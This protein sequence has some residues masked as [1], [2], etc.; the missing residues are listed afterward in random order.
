MTP[1]AELPPQQP[2][3]PPT[4]PSSANPSSS[5]PSPD[6]NNP[7]PLPPPET[8]ERITRVPDSQRPTGGPFGPGKPKKGGFQKIPPKF[9]GPPRPAGNF[10]RPQGNFNRPQGNFNRPSGNFDRPQGNFNRP[11]GNFDR[12]QGNFNRPQGNFDRPQGNFNR[13]AGNFDRPQ[14]GNFSRVFHGPPGTPPPAP[15]AGPVPPRPTPTD[16]SAAAQWYDS[17]VGDDGSEYHREVVLPG[18]MKLLGDVGGKKILDVACGQGVLARQLQFHG[19]DV[20]AFDAADGLIA[21]ARQRQ[22]EAADGG[23]P[24]TNLIRYFVADATQITGLEEGAY[25]AAA[26]LLAIQNIHPPQAVFTSVARALKPGAAFVVV[27]MH[28]AFRS[29]KATHWGWVSDPTGGGGGVQFRRVDKYLTPRKEPIL[30]HPGKA[31]HGAEGGEGYTWTFHRPLGDYIKFARNAGL[32][33]DALEEW[34]SHKVSDSGPRAPA[35]NL[36]R[37]EIPMFLA[38]RC[39]K[40]GTGPTTAPAPDP[41]PQVQPEPEPEPVQPVASEPEPQPETPPQSPPESKPDAQ[42]DSQ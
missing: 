17:L 9:G 31:A 8:P 14:G 3:V 10:D 25:D 39:V 4:P 28:P 42:P 26:C 36:A 24:P 32:M 22:V 19:A 21:A 40:V 30:T 5:G 11:S 18:T 2:P 23:M 12:P 29:P 38:L 20:T 35:E 1:M 15:R 27:M 37:K 7:R 41:E 33:V 6:R 13:P 34:I 16:W